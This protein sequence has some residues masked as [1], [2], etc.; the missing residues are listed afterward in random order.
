MAWEVLTVFLSE[1]LSSYHKR[2][3]VLARSNRRFFGDDCG[4]QGQGSGSLGP[5]TSG[6]SLGPAGS[7]FQDFMGCLEARN[8]APSRG[9]TGTI[10][11]SRDFK[12]LASTNF[13][14]GA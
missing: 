1:K 9:R 7:G 10:K 2:A 4:D 6:I 3:R 5:G 14:I 8:G 12:S 11:K 13:A